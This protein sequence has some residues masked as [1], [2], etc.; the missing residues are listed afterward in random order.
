MKSD[1]LDLYS[2]ELDYIFGRIRHL[3]SELSS[4]YV[5]EREEMLKEI[6]T[7][8]TQLNDE[9]FK[10]KYFADELEG[11]ISNYF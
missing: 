7:L 3:Q 10:V 1:L 2:N 8:K 11:K 5:S 9:L 4:A 6:D